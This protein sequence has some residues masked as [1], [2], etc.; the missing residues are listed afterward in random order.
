MDRLAASIEAALRWNMGRKSLSHLQWSDIW[1]AWTET[2]RE[3]PNLVPIVSTAEALKAMPFGVAS[4]VL[5]PDLDLRT[6]R[7]GLWND[8]EAQPANA[9]KAALDDYI[10]VVTGIVSE[11]GNLTLYLYSLGSLA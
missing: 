6:N 1:S 8:F 2:T 7:Q 11:R 4:V 10:T 3:R 5:V 9:R